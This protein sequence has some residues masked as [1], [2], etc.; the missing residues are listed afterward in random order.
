MG[1]FS[2]IFKSKPKKGV[3]TRV[4]FFTLTYS[5][6]NKNVWRNSN[7][8][9]SMSVRGTEFEPDKAQLIF[10]ESLDAEILKLDQKLT[11]RFIYEFKEADLETNFRNWRERFK[12][13]AVE[14]MLIFQGE[15]YWNITFED[16]KEPYAHF[17]LFMEG[18]KTTDFSIDT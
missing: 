1:L 2:N 15:N 9:R 17:T 5:K 3:E 13:I 12:I 14:V 7:S 4:G 16:L 6:G 10:L 18:H 8:E 11:E